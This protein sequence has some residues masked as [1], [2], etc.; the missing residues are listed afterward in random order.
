MDAS[1]LDA[2]LNGSDLAN[3]A[4]VSTDNLADMPGPYQKYHKMLKAGIPRP[5]VDQAMKRDG[6]DPSGFDKPPTSSS[7]PSESITSSTSNAA[8]NIQSSSTPSGGSSF[9]NDIAKGKSLKKTPVKEKSSTPSKMSMSS[10]S[11]T[12]SSSPSMAMSSAG[13]SHTPVKTQPGMLDELGSKLA[14]R[15][16][17]SS[18]GGSA[19]IDQNLENRKGKG[20]SPAALKPSSAT[21]PST[22]TATA[23]TT[24]TK[25]ASPASSTLKKKPSNETPSKPA[26]ITSPPTKVTEEPKPATPTAAPSTPV[27]VSTPK[28]TSQSGLKPVQQ[29]TSYDSLVSDIIEDL[30]PATPTITTTPT[31]T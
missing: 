3:A 1:G 5:A 30:K 24:P 6:I 18:S 14:K 16:Q 13:A 8:A 12:S 29:D 7:K 22:P 9:L 25:A 2:Y 31:S 20:E 23:A 26:T 19:S 15:A 21:K 27:A 28:S 10:S 17:V 4:P 11:G